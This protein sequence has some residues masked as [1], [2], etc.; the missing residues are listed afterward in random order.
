MGTIDVLLLDDNLT[1]VKIIKQLAEKRKLTIHH[2]TDYESL[3]GFLGNNDALHYYLTTQVPKAAGMAPEIMVGRAIGAI[4]DKG[5]IG[6]I[7]VYGCEDSIKDT[8]A[9]YN[10][11]PLHLRDDGALVR[12]FSGVMDIVAKNKDSSR[13][14]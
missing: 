4:R 12:I 10:V 14:S 1:R 2:A 13:P 9:N 6:A 11:P 3:E 8:G 7:G 5:K